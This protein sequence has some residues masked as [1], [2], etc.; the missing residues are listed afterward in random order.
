MKKYL[1]ILLIITYSL[2]A[3]PVFSDE[4]KVGVT[5]SPVQCAYFDE[6]W[7]TT[8]SNILAMDFDIIRLGAYWNEI[9]AK[10]GLYDFTRL[11]FLIKKAKKRGLPVVL[12]VGMKAPR[13]PEYFIPGWVLKKAKLSYACD[14]S[15]SEY[16]RKSTLRF[17]R[18]V[19]EHYNNEK[20]ITCWQVENEPLDRAGPD[21]WYISKDFLKQE[22]LLIRKTDKAQRPLMI[23]IATHPNRFL[24]C[25]NRFLSANNPLE[26]AAGICDILGLNIYP[27][28]GQ[29]FFSVE[30][31]FKT[32]PEQ[33]KKYIKS[34]KEHADKKNITLW[35]TELQAEPWDPG[36]LVH[37]DRAQPVT[38]SPARMETYFS[39]LRS[40][41]IDTIFLWGAEYWFF[42]KK[43]FHD[44]SWV[45][46]AH[47]LIRRR[48]V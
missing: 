1:I 34:I 33:R 46:A 25:I 17:V 11:D 13:W 21:M 20:A 9:E 15:G 24:R 38:S 32:S 47:E 4:V 27:A 8:Y 31:I 28:I 41:G 29:K 30:M 43:R 5:F 12:S 2:S 35:I 44:S 26:D 48:K 45:D 40:L 22:A 3:N 18:K 39:E 10:E 14:V 16:L 7:K 19:V 23:N 6:P 36:R 37:L 42:R